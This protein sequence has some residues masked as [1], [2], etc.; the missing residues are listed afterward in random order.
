MGLFRKG[1]GKKKMKGLKAQ[2]GVT[3]KGLGGV[4]EAMGSR[5]LDQAFPMPPAGGVGSALGLDPNNPTP[6]PTTQ[7]FGPGYGGMR[8][9]GMKQTQGTGEVQVAQ[10][11]PT[12][13]WRYDVNQ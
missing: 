4:V 12:S 11:S 6:T 3:T 10:I 5:L 13:G 2:Y 1:K 7:R 9:M 8:G